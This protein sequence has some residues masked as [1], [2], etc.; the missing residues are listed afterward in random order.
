MN[1]RQT[2]SYYEDL[3]C[4]YL[5]ENG[6][7]VVARNFRSKRGEIDIVA[8]D[9]KYLVF[10]E[11]KYRTSSRFGEAEEAVDPRKQRVICR[12]SDFYRKRYGI[13]ENFAIRY[14]VIAIKV[15]ETSAIH[16]RWHKN[17]FSYIPGKMW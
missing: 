15:D 1:K 10:I 7:R 6:A 12:V 4:D 8:R 5:A 3:A 16:I 2:G 17:A 11:V 13:G 9:D 14:D